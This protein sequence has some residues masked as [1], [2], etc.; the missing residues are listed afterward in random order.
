MRSLKIFCFLILTV[1]GWT[2]PSHAAPQKETGGQKKSPAVL[3]SPEVRWQVVGLRS[4]G[5]DRCPEVPGWKSTNWLDQ[6]LREPRREC[7]QADQKNPAPDWRQAKAADPLL[8]QLGLDRFCAYRATADPPRPFPKPLPAGLEAAANSRMAL[9]PSG[10]PDPVN[11]LARHFIDQAS[12]MPEAKGPEAAMQVSLNGFRGVPVR[13]VFIDTQ[14]DGEGVPHVPGPS[15]HG[16]TLVHLADQLICHGASPCPVELATRLALPHA[17]FNPDAP[18]AESAA[19]SPGGGLGLVDELAAAIVREVWAWRQSGSKRHLVLN[20]SVGWDGELLG[21]IGRRASPLKPDAQLVYDALRFARR[22]GA[23]V[24]A[25]A[26]NRRGGEESDWPLLPAAWELYR[27]SGL[28]R[29]LGPKP[30]YAVGGVDWQGL[31][32]PNYRRGGMP[33]R[34]AFGDHAVAPTESTDEPTAMYTGTSVSAAVVSSIAAAVWQLR[35][36]LGS[37]EVMRIVSQSGN[38]LP[39]RADYYALK[40]LWPFSQLV[41][42]PS[43]RRLSLCPAVALACQG[44]ARCTAP[45]CPD[46]DP[47]RHANLLSLGAV[48]ATPL[49]DLRAAALP[50]VCEPASHPAPRLF[51]TGGG[52]AI[53]DLM[54]A[55]KRVCPLYLLLDVVSQR[56]VRPQPEVN[57]CP[58][59]TF[60]PPS[61]M[62]AS[63]APETSSG[64][65]LAVEI[66][67]EWQLSG[68]T[69]ESAALDVDRYDGGR[70]VE[71]MTYAIPK[72]DLMKAG[73]PGGTHRL[74][75]KEVG[76]GGTL[77]HCTATLNFKVSLGGQIYSVQSPIYVDP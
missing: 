33:R 46:W 60:V 41:K 21:E 26:G 74:L 8:R 19:G 66:D 24:I 57:P 71:R 6:A 35:P 76:N 39:S 13:L 4:R 54:E 62:I 10:E 52:N 16:Y 63:L 61:S 72:Q 37:A 50:A 5:T 43:I 73:K 38:E 23:L 55:G 65:V 49:P 48:A 28:P 17:T 12:G 22:S 11:I 40:H 1:L 9:V 2:V 44:G 32:L 70:L 20:L 56:W 14:P 59:C 75:L 15:R 45:S 51:T 47:T 77:M 29:I 68:A 27:P 3:E 36:E 58:G 18:P 42:A 53:V 25:A 31:P 64:Y 69:I 30:V 67:P 34:A 7:G